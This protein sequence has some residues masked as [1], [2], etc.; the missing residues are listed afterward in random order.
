M[1]RSAPTLA[2]EQM[3][4]VPQNHGPSW[5]GFEFP[6]RVLANLGIARSYA[7]QGDITKASAAWGFSDPPGPA[8]CGREVGF[9][10]SG[11]KAYH[12]ACC[13]RTC[14][15]FRATSN[16]RSLSARVEY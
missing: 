10:Y 13:R 3:V 4:G 7:A 14:R 6:N 16:F 2:L 12:A 11:P 15:C 9:S 8:D 5:R 1:R